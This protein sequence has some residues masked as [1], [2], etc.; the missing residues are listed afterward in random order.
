MRIES[1]TPDPVHKDPFMGYIA[2]ESMDDNELAIDLGNAT[3]KTTAASTTT[4]DSDDDI[5]VVDNDENTVESTV[6]LASPTVTNEQG[7]SGAQQIFIVLL[8]D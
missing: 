1:N 6:P 2:D 3:T 5:I 7:S 8:V 4:V